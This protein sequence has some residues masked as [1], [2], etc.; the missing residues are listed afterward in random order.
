MKER[1]HGSNRS[2]MIGR[3]TETSLSRH[4]I[5]SKYRDDTRDEPRS[6]IPMA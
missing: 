1:K 4:P 5:E 2:C 3:I 6:A